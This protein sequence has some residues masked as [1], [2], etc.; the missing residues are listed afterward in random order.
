M[1]N[2]C[3]QCYKEIRDDNPLCSICFSSIRYRMQKYHNELKTQPFYAQT[4]R[5][6]Q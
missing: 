2:Q 4:L 1:T 5:N 6:K 3:K